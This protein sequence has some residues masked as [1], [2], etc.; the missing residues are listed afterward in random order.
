MDIP[1][2]LDFKPAC[3]TRL[4]TPSSTASI[5]YSVNVCWRNHT[6]E[7]IT[8]PPATWFQAKSSFPQAPLM[9]KQS[10]SC[11]TARHGFRSTPRAEAPPMNGMAKASTGCWRSTELDH[12]ISKTGSFHFL[13]F[14]WSRKSNLAERG[15]ES[16]R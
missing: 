5:R 9:N 6:Q 15:K 3:L 16:Y 14:C 13:I 11:P 12:T 4:Y 2:P 10:R 8:Q 1:K 7:P